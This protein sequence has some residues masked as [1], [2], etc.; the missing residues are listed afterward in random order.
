MYEG[1]EGM[2]MVHVTFPE[3]QTPMAKERRPTS[4]SQVYQ[5]SHS[6]GQI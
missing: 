3:E 2:S 6:Y 1:D 4:T 5:H